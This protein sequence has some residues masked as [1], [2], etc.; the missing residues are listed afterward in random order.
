MAQEIWTECDEKLIIHHRK[1]IDQGGLDP[2]EEGREERVTR[3]LIS[4]Y[5]RLVAPQLYGDAEDAARERMERD[6][7][8]WPTLAT[9]LSLE[10]GIWTNDKNH[11]WGC[12]VATWRTDVIVQAIGFGDDQ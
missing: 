1:R 12:G 3:E 6:L 2:D 10:A 5:V 11:F 4:N 8:D 7:D 9:A